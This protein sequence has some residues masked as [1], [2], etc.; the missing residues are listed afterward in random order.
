[1][2]SKKQRRRR[3]RGQSMVETILLVGI[4]GLG[5]AWLTM[6]LPDAIRTFYVNNLNVI[7]SP[8]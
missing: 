5:V 3:R 4:V 1:M 2:F 6:A 7:A 8:L